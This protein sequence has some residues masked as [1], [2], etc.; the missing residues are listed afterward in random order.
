MMRNPWERIA[1]KPPSNPQCPQCGERYLGDGKTP[2][3]E[4]QSANEVAERT[5]LRGETEELLAEDIDDA[6][7]QESNKQ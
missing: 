2:C 5:A 1:N 7:R 6:M 3:V 4:C